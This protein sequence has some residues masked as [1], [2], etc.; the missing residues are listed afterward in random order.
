MAIAHSGSLTNAALLRERL[1]LAGAILHSTIDAEVISYMITKARLKSGSIESAVKNALKEI[2]GAY[3]LIVMSPKKLV[4]ARDPHGFRP[5]CIGMLG[6][7]YLIASESC[8]FD[9][10]GGEFIRDVQPGEIIVIDESGMRSIQT[11]TEKPAGLCVFEFVYFARQDSVIE[12]MSVHET[13]RKAGE[14]LAVEHPVDA[15]VVI[16]VPESG[17]DAAMGYSYIAKIPHGMGFTKN[18]YVGRAFIQPVH[19]ERERSV[20]IK[21]NVIAATVKG[22]RVIMIDDSIVR[23]TTTGKIVKLVRDAG[24]TEVHVR[25]SAPPF[26]YPCYF[27]ADIDSQENLIACKMPKEKICAHIGADSLAYLSTESVVKIAGASG[28]GFCKGCFTGE[29]PVAKPVQ[30]ERDKF[31]SKIRKY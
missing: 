25:I 4:A 7:D 27:G 1:E 24:A 12:G 6:E 13:R 21:L 5:L 11:D 20:G 30:A 26:M 8:A 2:T 10:L 9:C 18:R 28:C 17:I 31:E 14:F 22:K 15:D 19:R 29:Y 16:G 3:S 23:G